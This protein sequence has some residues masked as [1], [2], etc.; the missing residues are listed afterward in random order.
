MGVSSSSNGC[1]KVNRVLFFQACMR[2]SYRPEADEK[3][4]PLPIALV[5]LIAVMTPPEEATKGS[6]DRC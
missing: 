2:D 5:V 1:G 3:L 4:I 6:C